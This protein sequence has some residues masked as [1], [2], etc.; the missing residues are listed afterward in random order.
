MI[1][2][3]MH[4][5]RR[6]RSSWEPESMQSRTLSLCCV[7]E[8]RK[9][10]VSAGDLFIFSIIICFCFV[11]TSVRPANGGGMEQNLNSSAPTCVKGHT[12]SC[13]AAFRKARCAV[14]ALSAGSPHKNRR[15]AHGGQLKE[16][17]GLY[18]HYHSDDS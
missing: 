2:V 3:D 14:T 4:V 13:G 9:L 17:S 11:F 8:Q 18:M 1:C 15:L 5:F 16:Q 10:A 7:P 6:W 12:A